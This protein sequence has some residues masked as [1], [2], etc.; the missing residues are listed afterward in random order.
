MG[1]FGTIRFIVD[2]YSK[3]RQDSVDFILNTDYGT[4]CLRP[5]GFILGKVAPAE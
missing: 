3:A 4:K 2:P 1:L 5:E